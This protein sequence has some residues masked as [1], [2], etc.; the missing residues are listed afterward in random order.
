MVSLSP[1][2]ESTEN[3]EHLFKEIGL[4]CRVRSVRFRNLPEHRRTQFYPHWL[5][6]AHPTADN[7]LPRRVSR[8]CPDLLLQKQDASDRARQRSVRSRQICRSQFLR[9]CPALSKTQVANRAPK[10]DAESPAA[11]EHPYRTRPF[12]PSRVRGSA[13]VAIFLPCGSLLAE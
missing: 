9:R 6:A 12:F 8:I 7:L 11:P 3:S 5:N 1:E 2:T 13:C 4:V 10:C